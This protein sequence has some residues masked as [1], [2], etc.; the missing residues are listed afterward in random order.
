M[1]D[2]GRILVVEDEQAMLFGLR[3]ILSKQGHNVEIAET[4]SAGVKKVQ[5]SF[6]D[7]VIT[8]LKM[9]G[10]DGIE[11]LRK[12]KEAYSDTLVIVITG[13]GTVESA[14]EAIKLGAYDY[15]TKPFEA[16]HIKMVVRKALKQISL[17]DENKY[18][19]EQIKEAK[20]FQNI[21]GKSQ[22]MQDVFKI[23][24]QV[25]K[26]NTTVL[27]LGE[28][29]TG[30][31][32]LARY[33]HYNSPR[34]EKVFVPV[35]CSALTETLLE[36]E[37]FGHEKGSFTGAL[38][39]KRGLIEI[40]SGGTFFFDEIGDVSPSIQG[41]LL[42]VLQER[43]F[44]RVGGT[45]IISADI[46]LIAATN[47]NLEQCIKERTFREDLYY[48]LNVVSVR[49]PPLRERKDDL[50]PLAQFFLRR[51]NKKMGK[52][53]CEIPQDVL[54]ILL[55]Y[56]WPGNVRELENVIERAVVL[57]TEESIDI[58]HL[59]DR[60][61]KAH[62]DTGPVF[63]GLSYKEAK[64]QVLDSFSKEF[65]KRLLQMS[66]GNISQAAKHAKMDTAN[67]R[68]LMRKY[69]IQSEEHK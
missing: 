18:L 15:I 33:I 25:A 27:L 32:L 66:K 21:I 23:A 5:E 3:K 14:V 50:L 36:S 65:V 67:F 51:F 20:D 8:D 1:E 42:R 38:S 17:R 58:S 10:V 52:K 40:A 29:G 56:D 34:K 61:L 64:Q 62:I 68:R 45:D 59:P 46:R 11:L 13:Y 16:E 39:T 41:K 12:T 28:S 69:D 35:N 49:L 6:F 26:T 47:K 4:G 53:I 37:L 48:R 44:M 57:S 43:E 30:K 9:P 31:D 2:K 54:G 63:R 7:I 19:K 22:K 24:D 55:G 60:L